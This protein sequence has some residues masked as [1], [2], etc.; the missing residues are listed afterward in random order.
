[1][2][3]TNYSFVISLDLRVD[4]FAV[5][6]TS[7]IFIKVKKLP[8]NKK[9]AKYVCQIINYNSIKLNTSTTTTSILKQN[10]AQQT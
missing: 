4:F 5:I 9:A 1:M 3:C 8:A 2:S 10:S 6:L 7:T